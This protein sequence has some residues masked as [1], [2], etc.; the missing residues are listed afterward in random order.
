MADRM[1]AGGHIDKAARACGCA[2]R[3][4][5]G[6]V[7]RIGRVLREG[8]QDVGDQQFLMLLFVIEAD[9]E[10]REHCSA[11]SAFGT[12][13]ISRSTAASTWAR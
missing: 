9:L 3:L 12:L 2:R 7:D 13:A 11:A 1:N 4:P 10:N 6:V 5:V 8:M